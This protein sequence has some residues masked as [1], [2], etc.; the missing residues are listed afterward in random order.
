MEKKESLYEGLEERK[1]KEIEHSRKRR[2]V[3]QGFERL[4]DTHA[5]DQVEDLEELIMKSNQLYCNTGKF[6]KFSIN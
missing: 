2:E 1:Q 6:C 4:A 3:L 5:A